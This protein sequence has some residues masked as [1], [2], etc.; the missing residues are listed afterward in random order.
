MMCDIFKEVS[1]LYINQTPL[2][3]SATAWNSKYLAKCKNLNVGKYGWDA[4]NFPILVTVKRPLRRLH[5]TMK[6]F[7]VD[8][9]EIP[10][11]HDVSNI[12]KKEWLTEA[13][14]SSA[15]AEETK[16]IHVATKRLLAS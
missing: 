11:R 15:S 3:Q 9:R 14:C 13:A 6:R 16:F 1:D 10:P 2:Q 12:S 5:D 7:C 4:S 8:R